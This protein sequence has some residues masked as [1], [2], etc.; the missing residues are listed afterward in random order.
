MAV[1]SVDVELSDE[2]LDEIDKVHLRA[3]NLCP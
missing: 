3:P 1:T 2:I